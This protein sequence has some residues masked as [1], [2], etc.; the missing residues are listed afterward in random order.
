MSSS[1]TV[2]AW[3]GIWERNVLIEAVKLASVDHSRACSV[4]V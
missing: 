2:V 1:A 3:K 4:F